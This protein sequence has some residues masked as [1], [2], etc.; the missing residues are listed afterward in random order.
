VAPMRWSAM[1]K[2]LVLVY[3][4]IGVAGLLVGF[5]LR[6]QA[7]L[8]N[9]SVWIRNG[10]VLL[11][12]GFLY[13]SVVRAQKGSRRALIRVRVLSLAIPLIVVV[14]VALPDGFPAWMKVQQVVAGLSVA[15]VA[16]LVNWPPARMLAPR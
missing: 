5:L 3:F 12:A 7:H 13:L 8:V 9:S 10:F 6:D 2:A 11:S 4:G 15:G 16:V 14:L 1:V